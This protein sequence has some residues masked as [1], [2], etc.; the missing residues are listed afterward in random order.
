MVLIIRPGQKDDELITDLRAAVLTHDESGLGLLGED[1]VVEY[2]ALSYTW[3]AP[4]FTHLITCNCLPFAITSNLDEALRHLRHTSQKRYVWVDAVCINQLD[5]REKAR[6]ISNLFRI[7]QR[8]FGVIAWL[9][10]E[11][12]STETAVALLE[13]VNDRPFSKD[14]ASVLSDNSDTGMMFQA[15]EG[16]LDLTQREWL[17]RAWVVQEV[18]AAS[19]IS[20]HCGRFELSFQV[21]VT[22]PKILRAILRHLKRD[23]PPHKL[24]SLPRYLSRETR[25][26]VP[27]LSLIPQISTVFDFLTNMRLLID[28][29]IQQGQT[30][31]TTLAMARDMTVGMHPRLS[32]PENLLVLLQ[33]SNHLR[34]EDDQDRIFAL[35]GIVRQIDKP[36]RER[37]TLGKHE[38]NGGKTEI[39]KKRRRYNNEPEINVDYTDS[40]CN[41]YERYT[42]IMIN[43]CGEF[44]PL[45]C[46]QAQVPQ[47]E[48]N[49]LVP[50]GGLPT[51]TPDWR[52]ITKMPTIFWDTDESL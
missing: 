2:E 27:P 7:F 30:G 52:N 1:Q 4:H 8:A 28:Q 29:N 22:A 11:V 36:V 39:P 18:F 6:Q 49:L 17:R 43:S 3:G 12:D 41:V 19:T 45:Y 48:E 14:A 9:G 26:T 21:F 13:E 20:V 16:L 24:L 47:E 51:W 10:P 31:Y 34:A 44:S 40:V 33:H 46:S 35:R 42:K 32:P 23:R 5:L 15:M 38:A 25:T 50:V 37:R